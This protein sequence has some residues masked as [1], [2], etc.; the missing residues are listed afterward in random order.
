MTKM[1]T[2]QAQQMW[3]YMNITR[4]T[5]DY[6]V[7]ELNEVGRLGWELV[8]ASY[9]KD[10]KTSLGDAFC[11][12]AILKRPLILPAPPEADEEAEADQLAE[13]SLEPTEEPES[14]PPSPESSIF[15]L[16]PDDDLDHYSG[17]Q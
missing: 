3:E 9:H 2:V 16:S 12:T 13:T 6:L 14:P 4:K 17:P 5:A 10:M 7:A 8:N 11:W 1:V 15:D